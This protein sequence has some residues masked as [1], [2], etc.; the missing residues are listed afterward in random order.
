M[1][2]EGGGKGGMYEVGDRGKEGEEG[3]GRRRPQDSLVT[4]VSRTGVISLRP[5]AVL[6]GR[7][8]YTFKI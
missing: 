1:G 5:I 7:I 8:S 2:R 6:K 4:A 3:G